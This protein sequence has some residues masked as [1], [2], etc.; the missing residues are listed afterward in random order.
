MIEEAILFALEKHKGQRRKG[1]KLPYIVHPMEVMSIIKELTKD[2]NILVAGILHDTVEDTD[3]TLEEIEQR[4]GKR[5]AEI[6][7]YETENKRTDIAKSLTWK[8]R[9][10][11]TIEK[12]NNCTDEG[13]L[14]VVLGDKLSNIRSFYE[15]VNKDR[16]TAFDRFNQKDPKEHKWYY[17]S[18]L[19][20]LEIFKDTK[21][22]KELK[23]LIEATF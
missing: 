14:M 15:L 10:T 13:V 1:D 12:L 19:A 7:S 23:Y 9:K 2:E 20:K 5:V 21:A 4:F 18:I 22:Y 17:E 8:I 16:A 11:E 6:V 3:C